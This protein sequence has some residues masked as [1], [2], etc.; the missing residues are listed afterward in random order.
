MFAVEARLHQVHVGEV[1]RK[2]DE[3]KV[4][5]RIFQEDGSPPGNFPYGSAHSARVKLR[6]S[7]AVAEKQMAGSNACLSPLHRS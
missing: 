3:Q 5:G 2:R 6:L 4:D 7:S 1:T